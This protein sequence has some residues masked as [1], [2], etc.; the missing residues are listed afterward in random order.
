MNKETITVRGV[1]MEIFF[2]YEPEQKE[3]CY[4]NNGDPGEPG[5][6]EVFEI[7]KVIVGGVD[8]F[9]LMI[10]EFEKDIVKNL[11]DNEILT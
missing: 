2:N 5:Y 4:M 9:E 7:D 1:E 8:I 10:P 6:P 11:K 3:R